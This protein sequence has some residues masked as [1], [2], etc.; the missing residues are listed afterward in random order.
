MAN[1][2]QA[3]TASGLNVLA[4]IWLI[5]APY[6]L[7]YAHTSAASNDITIGIIVGILAL[8]RLVTPTTSGW[9]SW[10]NVIFGLWLIISPFFLGYV[11][12]ASLWN[13]IILGIIVAA[14][15]AWSSSAATT[16]YQA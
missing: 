13:D 15:A 11:N 14:L 16:Q 8:I 7:N 5:V 9:L 3:M 1:R 12:T 4:A 6:V 10:I 2:E